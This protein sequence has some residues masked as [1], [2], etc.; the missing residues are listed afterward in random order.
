M[1]MPK[2]G[3]RTRSGPPADPNATRRHGSGGEWETIAGDRKAIEVPEWPLTK[4]SK[5]ELELWSDLWDRPQSVLWERNNQ[6]FEVA[7]LCRR[8]A[9]AEEPGAPVALG[10]LVRQMMDSLLLTMPSMR[11]A[12][13]RISDVAAQA[14]AVQTPETRAS[15]RERLRV[16][17]DSG[18][19]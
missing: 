7:L 14:P 1:A 9:E 10:T 15:S 13:V 4:A 17:R 3:A 2:G 18:A 8:F 5:R 11:A 12:R 16:V 19:A 6:A